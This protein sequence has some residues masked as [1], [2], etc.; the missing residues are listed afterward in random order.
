VNT[1]C[2]INMDGLD[3]N[4]LT[5]ILLRCNKSAAALT[6][7]LWKDCLTSTPSLLINSMISSRGYHATLT[8]MM[9]NQIPTRF[10]QM[11]A[12]AMHLL[13]L[14]SDGFNGEL[15]PTAVLERSLLDAALRGN[16]AVVSFL[17][18]LNNSPRADCRDGSAL[19][20]AAGGGH[21]GVCRMLLEWREHAPRAD[22]DDGSALMEAVRKGHEGIC[23]MLLGWRQHAPRADCLHGSALV[24]AA[25]GGHEGICRMLLECRQHAPRADCLYGSA[26]MGAVRKG[27]EGICRMLLGWREHAPRADC[28]HGLA[29]VEAARGGHEGI[30][31]LLLGWREHA[32][33]QG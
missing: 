6:S 21:E 25:G 30:Y 14:H 33:P 17:L 19:V 18:R 13:L 29:L 28:L 11:H 3:A 9:S 32:P 10:L 24:W 27:H 15:T 31:R 26:L 8:R 22:C 7:R 2:L 1:Q 23:S 4:L 16:Q 5:N 20:A 12:N